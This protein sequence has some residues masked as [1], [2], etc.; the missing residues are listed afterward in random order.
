[1]VLKEDPPESKADSGRADLQQMH[2]GPVRTS[3]VYWLSRSIGFTRKAEEIEER[4]GRSIRAKEIRQVQGLVTFRKFGFV[5]KAR[6]PFSL[7]D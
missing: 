5:A 7:L 4:F 3:H 2:W 1:V 6:A